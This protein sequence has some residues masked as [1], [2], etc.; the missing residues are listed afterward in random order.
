MAPQVTVDSRTRLAV[1][2]ALSAAVLLGHS[3]LFNFVTDDA[4]IS[5]RYARS[6]AERGE[7]TFNPGERVEGYTNFLWTVLLAA[8]IKLGVKPELSSR[9]LAALFAFLTFGV[10]V[11]F[12]RRFWPALAH[13]GDGVGGSADGA[14]IGGDGG[15]PWF[16]I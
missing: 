5:F 7:L 4:Y 9:L 2:L 3:L 10:L 14:G 12:S 1:A 11:R 13:G 6:L 15:S 8:G 16:A